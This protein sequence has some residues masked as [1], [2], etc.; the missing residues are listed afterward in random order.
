MRRLARGGM[1]DVYVA[2][3]T[4]GSSVALKVVAAANEDDIRRATREAAL[5]ARVHHPNVVP[6]V[7]AGTCDGF[8]FCAMAMLDGRSLEDVADAPLLPRRAA[9]LARQVAD[10]LAAA[11]ACGVVHRDVTPR[12]VI[13]VEDNEDERAILVDFGIAR[14]DAATTM[15]RAGEALGT[16]EYMAPEQARGDSRDAEATTDVWGLGATLYRLVAGRTPFAGRSWNEIQRAILMVDPGRLR[17]PPALARIVACCLEKAPEHRYPSAA[18]LRDD[19]DRFLAGHPVTAKPRRWRKLCR[20]LARRRAAVQGIAAVGVATL[21]SLGVAQWALQGGQRRRTE[22]A[23]REH[24]AAAR[25]FAA[26]GEV[27]QAWRELREVELRYRDTPALVDAYWAMVELVARDAGEDDVLG[28]EVWLARLAER[29]SESARAHAKLGR[30][31]ENAGFVADAARAYRTA[32]DGGLAGADIAEARQELAWVALLSQRA[33]SAI[34]GRILGVGDLDGDRR[35]ELLVLTDD[36]ILALGW[37]G[38]HWAERARYQVAPDDRAKLWQDAD[39]SGPD[40]WIGQLAA[41]GGI[42]GRQLVL[43]MRVWGFEGGRVHLVAELP[44]GAHAIGD[45]DGDGRD[46]LMVAIAPGT[47][48]RQLQMCRLAGDG[49]LACHELA[50][51]ARNESSIP[52]LAVVDLDGD[53]R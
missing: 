8:A 47:G 49:A 17:C 11:H 38:G 39:P 22:D 12:N 15:T 35:P 30:I 53:G 31:Y 37:A 13:V 48:Q 18:A 45:L 52:A 26:S 41:L 23:A 5:L 40:R 28:Q 1:G 44:Y 10:A 3:G 33:R 16:P 29:P 24:V 51:V 6:V 14:S 32:L 20:S 34:S 2:R 36:A 4:D 27:A 7:G 42:P 50:S 43:R 46:D 19:L 9:A 21:V 25:R